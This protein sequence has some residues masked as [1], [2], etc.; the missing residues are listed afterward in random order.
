MITLFNATIDIAVIAGILSIV[1]KYIQNKYMNHE[2]LKLKQTRIKEKQKKIQELIKKGDEDSKNK[3]AE[4]EREMMEDAQEI[5]QGSMKGMMFT[6]L[7]IIPLFMFFSW[8]YSDVVIALPFP[9]PFFEKFEL[10][11]PFS[12]INFKLYHYTNWIGWYVLVSLICNLAINI[13]LKIY[14]AL[15]VK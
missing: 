7:L 11:N 15:V 5:M 1:S 3:L 10:L 13:I 8:N 2:E 9:V 12:W 4:L 14:R 6:M